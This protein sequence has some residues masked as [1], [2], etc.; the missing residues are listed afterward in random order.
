[1][2][3]LVRRLIIL[4][5]G[6]LAGVAAWPLAELIVFHQAAFPTYLIF[7]AVLG[8]AVGVLMGAFFGAAEGITARVKS[9]I[10]PGI[11]VGAAVGIVG[12][13]AGFLVGQAA[14]LVIGELA[15]R[16]FR[17]FQ[18]IGLPISRAIGWGFLGIFVG[19]VEGFRARSGK[20]IAVGVPGGLLGGLVGG[21]LLEYLRVL[22]PAF[23]LNRLVG[24]IVLGA[25]IAVFYGLIEQG[26]AHGVLRVL[27]GALKGKE[28]LLTQSRVTIGRSRRNEV[29]LTPYEDLADRQAQI[30][31]RRGEAVLSNLQPKRPLLV[32][33]RPIGGRA[34]AGTVAGGKA[35]PVKPGD[36]K[37]AER[38]AGEHRLKYDDVIQVGSVKLFYRVP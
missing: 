15:L 24:L 25:S 21:F 11:L 3:T 23:R 14:L 19:M 12:G 8:A 37:A 6:V 31:V 18:R 33:D 29:A 35:A 9:R 16:S 22:V 17:S 38:A 5:I 7:V 30:R 20:K 13:A 36:G 2:S 34:G 10:L 4:C 32:N 27:N 28:Y 1:M 26:L